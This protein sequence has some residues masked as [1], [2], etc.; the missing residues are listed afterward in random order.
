MNIINRNIIVLNYL[1]YKYSISNNSNSIVNILNILNNSTNGNIDRIN[2]RIE[3]LED[4]IDRYNKIFKYSMVRIWIYNNNILLKYKRLKVILY[5]IRLD[6]KSI[7]SIYKHKIGILMR[8]KNIREYK[9]GNRDIFVFSSSIIDD[10]YND[11]DNNSTISYDS[12]LDNDITMDYDSISRIDREIV[13]YNRI[14]SRIEKSKY[15]NIRG[16]L[17]ILD[18]IGI[19]IGN[20]N[21][22]IDSI[23]MI[24]KEYK[25]KGSKYK[26][27]EYT[28]DI[29]SII[30]MDYN[31]SNIV[32]NT[33]VIVDSSMRIVYNR[34]IEEYN[35]IVNRVNGIDS[36]R[37]RVDTILSKSIIDDSNSIRNINGIS[38][39]IVELESIYN[40]SIN[41]IYHSTIREIEEY[42]VLIEKIREVKENSI[43]S[44]NSN[45]N[46]NGNSNSIIGIVDT[47]DTEEYE[48]RREELG[49]IREEYALLKR[50]NEF[51]EERKELLE[52]MR[53]FEVDASDPKRLFRSSFQLISEEKFRKIA[54]PTLLRLEKEILSLAV[55]Y[56]QSTGKEVVIGGAEVII[57]LKKEIS[58]RIINPN[59]FIT[60]RKR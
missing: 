35:K 3:Y 21:S 14:Y 22:I 38:K 17:G 55:S 44:S 18:R 13:K 34:Y 48:R 56:T 1:R 30:R 12:L 47:V 16:I 49:R 2:S 59:I 20:K 28:V 27:N 8:I 40:E 60:D 5:N 19:I 7:Y 53:V 41:E 15:D 9:D 57:A 51:I 58:Q 54:V 32:Y 33:L 11:N 25:Y 26:Y 4:I 10:I 6:Y 23:S 24:Y 46:S 52:K 43:K 31:S 45:G 29:G 42:I 37:D 39:S 36:I 50:I